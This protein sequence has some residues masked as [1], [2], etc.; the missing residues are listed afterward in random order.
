[1]SWKIYDVDDAKDSRNL[2]HASG[3]V[4]SKT[5]VKARITIR[6]QYWEWGQQDPKPRLLLGL[7]AFVMAAVPTFVPRTLMTTAAAALAFVAAAAV[8]L[9]AASAAAAV[10]ILVLVVVFVLVVLV[11]AATLRRADYS[12]RGNKTGQL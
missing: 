12:E 7:F 8:V 3:S 5:E 1:M 9:T 10:L 2:A 11:A 6:T 4:R